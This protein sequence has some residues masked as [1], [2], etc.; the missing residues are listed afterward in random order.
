MTTLERDFSPQSKSLKISWSAVK[1]TIWFRMKIK[2]I[3]KELLYNQN[4]ERIILMN[5][6]SWTMS[7]QIQVIS[8]KLIQIYTSTRIRH[9]IVSDQPAGVE[10]LRWS[11]K[12][13]KNLS[14]I[15]MVKNKTELLTTYIMPLF[16]QIKEK[17][18]RREGHVD[19][20]LID[21]GLK[22]KLKRTASNS[23]HLSFALTDWHTMVM[24]FTWKFKKIN[25][26][27]GDTVKK[28]HFFQWAYI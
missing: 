22:L 26:K 3:S 10:T 25:R 21:T 27:S 9:H 6:W 20:L 2:I 16:H 13:S 14:T 1:T 4:E 11:S 28:V 19:Q 8:F 18:I 17:M 12:A 23:P 15:S 7:N 5:K 24:M